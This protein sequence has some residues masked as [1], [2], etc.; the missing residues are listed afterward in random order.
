M[1]PVIQLSDDDRC[2]LQSLDEP[3]RT[4]PELQEAL[5]PSTLRGRMFLAGISF[6]G[7]IFFADVASNQRVTGDDQSA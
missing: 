5:P 2:T 1:Q 3:V 4:S 7:L 6:I